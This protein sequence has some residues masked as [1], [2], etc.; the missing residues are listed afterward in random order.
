M[1]PAPTVKNIPIDLIRPGSQQARKVFNAEALAELAE[2]IK[3]SGIVQPLVLRT[4]V[5]GYEI[6]AGERRWRAARAWLVAE[7]GPR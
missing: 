5:W 6:L 3:E 2:S 7:L 1:S 4:R